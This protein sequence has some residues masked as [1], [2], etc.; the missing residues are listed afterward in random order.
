MTQP[1][2]LPLTD[3]NALGQAMHALAAELYPLCRSMTGAGV[4][5]TLEIL[6]RLVPLELH[7]VPTGTQVLDWTVPKEWEIR[8]AYVKNPDGQR[9]IDF[10]RL[11]LHVVQYSV[12]VRA[13]M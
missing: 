6:G 7:E 12:P 11:N 3:P 9:V 13:R 10:Q 5:R 8:D 4:R 1:H 2:L